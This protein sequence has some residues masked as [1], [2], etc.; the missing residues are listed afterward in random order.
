M[1]AAVSI[2]EVPQ[3]RVLV[4]GHGRHGK[5]TVCEILQET[6]GWEFQS[7]SQAALPFIF[8][9]LNAALGNRYDTHEQAYADRSNHRM[10]WMELIRLLNAGDLSTLSRMILTDCG[11]YCGMRNAEEFE[12]SKHLYD[13]ILWVDASHRL[14][15]DPSMQI[16]YDP[17]CMT[18][19]DNNTS[20]ADLRQRLGRL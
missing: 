13:K 18:Y 1:N 20:L 2:H 12:A 16:A 7:S 10:L 6:R 5:D 3:P 9:S 19:V 14:P 17:R 15:P 4:L 8:P 11:V